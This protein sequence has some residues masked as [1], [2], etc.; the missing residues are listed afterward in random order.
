MLWSVLCENLM[1]YDFFQTR[2]AVNRLGLVWTL[3]LLRLNPPHW[4]QTIWQPWDGPTPYFR[5]QNPQ[6]AD[7]GSCKKFV[8]VTVS[9]FVLNKMT[10]Y[11]QCNVNGCLILHR[12]SHKLCESQ[13]C[14]LLWHWIW[15]LQFVYYM[16]E[17]ECF[18]KEPFKLEL[19]HGA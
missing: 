1:C 7:P 18:V 12:W 14:I 17:L 15:I 10:I 4:I 3:D 13:P 19:F 5:V 6:W 2:A 11:R 16:E 8:I 9:N